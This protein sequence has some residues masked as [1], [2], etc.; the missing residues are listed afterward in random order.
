MIYRRY[1]N[2]GGL[3]LEG[4]EIVPVHRLTENINSLN[5]FNGDSIKV[6][7]YGEDVLKISDASGWLNEMEFLMGSII[8]NVELP[9]FL[10]VKP[11]DLRRF[12]YD[13][14]NVRDLVSICIF[15]N[16]RNCVFIRFND[17]EFKYVQDRLYLALQD[18]ST[19]IDLISVEC[20]LLQTNESKFSVSVK[21]G[22]KNGETSSLEMDVD[23]TL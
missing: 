15:D 12:A 19:V 23:V 14:K 8:Y 21:F 7:Y 6:M 5:P 9:K 13:H 4:I 1:K 17:S 20:G 2:E 18:L 10:Q 16:T 11:Q 3:V 22:H